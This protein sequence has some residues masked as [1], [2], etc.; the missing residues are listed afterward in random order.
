MHIAQGVLKSIN[1]NKLTKCGVKFV[2]WVRMCRC[3]CAHGHCDRHIYVN[4]WMD[5]CVSVGV[6]SRQLIFIYSCV[7]PYTTHYW[8]V[9]RWQTGSLCSTTRWAETSR[10]LRRYAHTQKKTLTHTHFMYNTLCTRQHIHA[11]AGRRVHD[12]GVACS[13]HGSR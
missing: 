10:R 7:T 1:V 2:F 11:C 4:M 9:H 12:R 13:R 6:C 3:G 8:Y 5:M